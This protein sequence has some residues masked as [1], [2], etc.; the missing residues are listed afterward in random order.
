LGFTILSKDAEGKIL[1]V[2]SQKTA[3]ILDLSTV[4]GV[5]RINE[6]AINRISNDVAAGIMGTQR[7]MGTANGSLGLSGKGEIIGI[8]DTGLDTGDPKNMHKD[9]EKRVKWIKSY[10]I[11]AEYEQYINNPGGNDGPADLDEGHGTHVA[12]SVLG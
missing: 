8:C 11:T 2:E 4:H 12:G 6:R 10:P 1:I 9:F 3:R 5:R 7:S